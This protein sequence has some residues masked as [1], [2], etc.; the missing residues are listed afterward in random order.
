MSMPEQIYNNPEYNQQTFKDANTHSTPGYA[1][2]LKELINS[3][4]DLVQSEIALATAEIKHVA[5]ATS[6]DLVKVAVF[7][8]IAAVS[9]LPFIAFLVIGLGEL[10]QRRYWLSSLIVAVVFAAVGGLLAYRSLKKVTDHDI[11]FTATKNSLRRDKLVI[12][13][14]VERVK[15]AV[16][17]DYNGTVQLH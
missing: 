16:K 5:Q 12:Q 2:A 9:L 7:G 3:S 17:G 15:T 8:T 4:K 14:N 1:D 6:R 10:L 11:D 13:S